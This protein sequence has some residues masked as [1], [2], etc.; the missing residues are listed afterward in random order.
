MR[1]TFSQDGDSVIFVGDLLNIHGDAL[2]RIFG[3]VFRACVESGNL[4]HFNRNEVLADD[5]IQFTIEHTDFVDYVFSS[6]NVKYSDLHYATLVDGLKNW[7][8]NLAQSN[9]QMNVDNDWAISLQISRTSEVP[10]GFG[11]TKKK[12]FWFTIQGEIERQG[13]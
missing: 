4:Q 1:M 13:I 11:K 12:R 2:D 10:Q 8:S 5:F 3:T 9:R 7:L 6:R